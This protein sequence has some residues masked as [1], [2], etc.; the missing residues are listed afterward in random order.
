MALSL[1]TKT[2][3]AIIQPRSFPLLNAVA[4]I[5]RNHP[6]LP[7][8]TVEGHT[9]DRGNDAYNQD[10][11]QRRAESVRRY[12]IGK[13]IPGDR[14]DAK[15]YGESRPIMPN[16]TNEHRSANRRVEFKIGD[17]ASANTG[18]THDTMDP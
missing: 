18:P 15:G 13:G 3:K 9:D 16:D 4:N 17:I 8:V 2:N 7:K 14:L 10:L 11:S 12:L 1:F 5:I 6:E